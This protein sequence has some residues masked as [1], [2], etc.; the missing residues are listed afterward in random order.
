M[1]IALGTGT[2]DL[3][4]VNGDLYLVSDL[5]AT[6]QRLKIKLQ[7]FLGEWFLDENVGIPFYESVFLK[8]P[9]LAVI[10]AIFRRAILSD[11]AV[12]TI[13]QFDFTFHDSLRSGSLTFKA[14]TIDGGLTFINEMVIPSAD[15]L[16]LE[17]ETT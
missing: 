7:F 10:N 14:N 4:I 2:H 3:D 12:I 13:N 6:A 9:N 5:D 11:E 15:R 17:E 8:N 1:D 16:L